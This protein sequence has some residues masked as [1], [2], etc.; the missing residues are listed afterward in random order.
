[1]IE[2]EESERRVTKR[3]TTRSKLEKLYDKQN[4]SGY[5][6]KRKH[7]TATIAIPNLNL[8]YVVAYHVKLIL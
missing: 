2:S 1:M 6:E 8:T 4:Y 5:Y 3:Y 7:K